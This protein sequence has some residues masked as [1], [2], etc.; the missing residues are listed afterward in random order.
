M[1]LELDGTHVS[2]DRLKHLRGLTKMLFLSLSDTQ[3]TDEG[4]KALQAALPKC[5][6]E[7][8]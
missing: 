4:V 3:V 6:I 7:W 5:K 8:K 2:D 1:W